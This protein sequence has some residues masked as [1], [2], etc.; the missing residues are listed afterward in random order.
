MQ[1]KYEMREHDRLVFSTSDYQSRMQ[2]LRQRMT[3]QKL[4]WIFVSEP[5]NLCYLSGHETS[6]Y[7]TVQGMLIGVN[8]IVSSFSRIL[9]ES[10]FLTR[11]WLTTTNY[12]QDHADPGLELVKLLKSFKVHKVGLELGGNFLSRP[13]EACLRKEFEV[14]DC[15]GIVEQGRL[16]KSQEEL[17]LLASVARIT[18]QGMQAGLDCIKAG[19]KENEIAAVVHQALYNAGGHYPSVPPYIVSGKRCV[20][21][22]ATWEDRAVENGDCV[23]LEI[24]GCVNRYHTAMMRTS[25]VGKV[26]KEIEIGESLVLE[27]MHE[28]K[29]KMKPGV[30][31]HE[32]DVC[33]RDQ[34]RYDKVG[35]TRISRTGYSL[36][37]AFAPSWDEG[38]LISLVEG[39]KR[40]LKENMVF[41]LIPWLQFPKL[42]CIMGISETVR[43]TPEGAKSL[44]KMPMKLNR[45]EN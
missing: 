27:H 39:E 6:G 14:V 31:C 36:G 15:S 12:Y 4:D 17:E 30:S 35:A 11:T 19:I 40:S 28:L 33:T 38:H 34:A 3:D 2:S 5:D 44:F 41:H 29:E 21:G 26:P 8:G 25:F 45:I 22:H 42:G 43:V 9:E 7:G 10:N 13:V 18:E 16:I 32:I 37:I 24:A 23:F 20:V 1:L